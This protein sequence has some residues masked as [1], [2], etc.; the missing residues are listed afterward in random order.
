VGGAE[1]AVGFGLFTAGLLEGVWALAGTDP[2][3]IV[4]SIFGSSPILGRS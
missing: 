2:D 3:S 1:K 4:I